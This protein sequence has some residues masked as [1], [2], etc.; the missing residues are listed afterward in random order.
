[1]VAAAD[2][3]KLPLEVEQSGV[4]RPAMLQQPGV[5]VGPFSAGCTGYDDHMP[6]AQ[7]VEPD[8]IARRY[9]LVL[10]HP[11]ELSQC[12]PASKSGMRLLRFG[13]DP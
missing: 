8:G 6:G 3:A 4:G 2:A 11:A 9:V 10:F 7:I 13:G 1:V 5:D 12:G